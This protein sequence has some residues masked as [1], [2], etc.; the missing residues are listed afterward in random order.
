VSPR[1]AVT[2]VTYNSAPL[3]ARCLDSVARQTFRDLGVW[4]WDN[5]S[6]D[7]TLDI[8]A[9]RIDEL[10]ATRFSNAN[11]GFAAA[12]NRLISSTD[13]DYVLALNPDVVL[14][15]DYVA[16]LH[17]ALEADASAG[18]ATGKLWRLPEDGS[19]AAG[20]E[21]IL[22]TAGIYFTTNQRHLDRGSG[23]VDRGQYE[24]REYV[25]GASGAAAFYRR[26]MLDD[27]RAGEEYFDE[28]FFSFREDADL[29]WRAQWLGWRC[30]YAPGARA[31]HVR[32]VLPERRRQLPAAVNM[33]SFKNRF[34]LRIKNM[35]AGTYA[36]LFVP[37]TLRDLAAVGY[38]LARE[39]SSLAAL[40]LLWKAI[41]RAL[42]F[43]RALARHRRVA[44]RE[45]RSWFARRPVSRPA[46]S[47]VNS[48]ARTP[49]ASPA[50][51]PPAAKPRG[52]G[53][54]R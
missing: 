12:Q 14:E 39:P 42:A 31:F 23:E 17:E 38:V 30:L 44:P 53:G 28:A 54:S 49:A 9:D 1:V 50:A 45:I 18:S 22:D 34:L 25:F 26:A 46:A 40:P 8:V 11:V 5:A 41:P 36:R 13:S 10:R 16:L 29:A 47:P 6:D 21:K 4:L 48:S 15:P 51:P 24:R 20:A 33:H 3:L 32:R 37:I 52:S 35:D 27:T 19:A 43:R 7:G 2:I